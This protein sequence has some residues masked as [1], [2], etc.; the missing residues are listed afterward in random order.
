MSQ[1]RP[2][3]KLI[4][5]IRSARLSDVIDAL[6]D[7]ADIEEADMHGYRG[8]P[9]RTACFEGNP[10]VVR[11]LLAHGANP[12]SATS[13]GSGAPLRLAL[14]R[15]HQDIVALLLQHGA[16]PPVEPATSQPTREIGCE[17]RAPAA[18]SG[19]PTAAVPY[20]NLIEF[21]PTHFRR[22]QGSDSL[23]ADEAAFGTAT[24]AISADLMFL[25]EDE[26]PAPFPRGQATPAG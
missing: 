23:A 14:R 15:G 8:L 4:T 7:G 26:T 5:A 11:E 1:G 17:A 3:S 12:N 22:G 20:D 24:E 9:L 6:R 16:T 21:T 25:E 2:P 19:Q 18:P 13:D 10:A